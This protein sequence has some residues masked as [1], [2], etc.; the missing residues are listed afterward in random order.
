[1]AQCGEAEGHVVGVDSNVESCSSQPGKTTEICT[2]MRGIAS[3][4]CTRL[5]DGWMQF[6]MDRYLLIILTDAKTHA[7]FNLEH[8]Q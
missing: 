6:E 5:V 3:V 8:T 1:M 2:R 4:H 7:E